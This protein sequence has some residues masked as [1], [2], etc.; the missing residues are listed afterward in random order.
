MDTFGARV[1]VERKARGLSQ[2]ALGKLAG[3]L[4]QQSIHQIETNGTSDTR[5]AVAIAQALNVR[6][7]W[8]KT[9]Q[10]PKTQLAWEMLIDV[11]DLPTDAQVAMRALATA[12][13]SGQLS[14]RRF[15]ALTR[16]VL[17]D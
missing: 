3:D 4:S 11:S 13:A 12:L 15:V 5:H 7:E 16:A 17:D 10:G 1:K 2:A 9:G 14:A 6:A 8:L